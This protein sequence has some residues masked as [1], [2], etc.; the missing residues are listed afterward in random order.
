MIGQAFPFAPPVGAR[1]GLM[2]R[3]KIRGELRT[4][5]ECISQAHFQG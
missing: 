4:N 2:G 3:R 5:A 1:A